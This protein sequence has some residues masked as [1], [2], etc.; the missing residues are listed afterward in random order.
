MLDLK[1]QFLHIQCV[2]DHHKKKI[3]N[4]SLYYLYRCQP[5]GPNCGLTTHSAKCYTSIGQRE[6]LLQRAYN[7]CDICAEAKISVGVRLLSG[8]EDPAIYLGAEIKI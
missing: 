7:L 3:K 5:Q 2:C 6:A 8:F 1:N 4:H